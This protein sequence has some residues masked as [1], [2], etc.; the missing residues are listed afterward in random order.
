MQ[1]ET[2][3][4]QFLRKRRF[5]LVLPLLL[6]PFTTLLFWSLGGGKSDN[7]QAGQPAAKGGLNLQLP[8]AYLKDD[9]SLNKLSYYE[10]AASDSE[11][12]QAQIKNDPNNLKRKEPTRDET[13]PFKDTGIF[14]MVYHSHT[15]NKGLNTSPFDKAGNSD[16]AETKIYQRLNELNAALNQATTQANK[17]RGKPDVS[18]ASNIAV[19]RTDVDRLERMMNSSKEE[20][21]GEDPEMKQLNG[22]MD[23]I[24]DIQHPERV[25]EKIDQR[26]E[27]AVVKSYSVKTNGGE[28][29][30]SLLS[31]NNSSFNRNDQKQEYTT[32]GF[33][34]L[35]DDMEDIAEKSN[36]IQAV[37]HETRTVVEGAIVKLRLKSEVAINGAVVPKGSFV[38]GIASLNGERLLIKISSIRYKASLFPVQLSV[39]DIDGMEGVYVPG[40]ITR[41]VAKNSADRA[42]QSLGMATLNPSLG[43]QAAS[44]GIEA[45]KTLMS[46]KAKLIKVTLKAG[47][48]VFLRDDKE[49]GAFLDSRQF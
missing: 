31:N 38:Y 22:M 43:A 4:P 45:A 33:F 39:V 15:E 28:S 10:K 48:Q 25:T 9:K 1:T 19:N 36:T 37:V 35:V 16:P 46:R 32:D 5:F 6:L 42:V 47:Y 24:L 17:P 11:K 14:P 26:S 20:G 21:N 8:D 41:D 23:K 3:S 7:A 18:R 29:N 2:L 49:K 40:A 13:S 12:L 44:A 30:T 27:K 34:S